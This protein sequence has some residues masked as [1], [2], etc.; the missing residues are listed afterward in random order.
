MDKNSINTNVSY[1]SPS[2]GTVN[3]LSANSASSAKQAN[4]NLID[5]FSNIF[6]NPTAGQNANPLQNSFANLFSIDSNPVMPNINDASKGNTNNQFD[7]ISGFLNMEANNN[8]AANNDG[9]NLMGNNTA[10]N[11]APASNSNDLLNSLG[12]VRSNFNFKF[13]RI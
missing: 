5:D 4:N 11:S 7:L 8:Q 13:L 3:L 6:G 1:S 2:N 9:F 12:L 10:A